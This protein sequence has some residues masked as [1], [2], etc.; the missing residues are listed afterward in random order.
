MISSSEQA[1]SQARN[2]SDANEQRLF[3]LLDAMPVA[4]FIGL[5]GGRPYYA[6]AEAIRI[7]GRGVHP[8]AVTSELATVYQ[9][10]IAGTDDLYP[11][12]RI[13]MVRALAGETVHCDD[14]EIRRPDGTVVP[15]ELW[16]TPVFGPAGSID[17][18]IVT[19]VETTERREAEEANASQA[20][21]IE[22]AHDAIFVR[23]MSSLI[24]FWN[25]GAERT[26]G[27]A[28]AEALGKV[29]HELL[30]TEFPEPLAD[31]KAR[32]AQDGQ[33]EGE[34]VHTR[35]DG[36]VIVV[37]SRWVAYR[38]TD[39]R[40]AGAIE[41]NRDVTIPRQRT[42]AELLRRASALEQAN[43]QLARSNEELEQFAY[44]A[45]H[46]L[47]EP[48]RAISGPISL[49]ARRY[50]G[51]LDAEADQFIEFAVDGCRRMQAII[52]DLLAL[53]RAGRVDGELQ[54]VD[55]NLLVKSV[56]AG[57]GAR[58][59]ETGAIV[60][61][62]PLPTVLSQPTQLGQVFQNLIANALKFIPPGVVPEVVV[63]A[64]RVG[65]EWDFSVTDNGIGIEP[66]HRERIFGMF[67]RLHGRSEYEGSGIGLAL[68]KRIVERQGGR[69]GVDAA[70][71]GQGSCFWFALPITSPIA[72]P[73]ASSF[74]SAEA[75]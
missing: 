16:A 18:S 13:P 33:W 72:S 14:M 30:H 32:V 62:D 22:L 60:R 38:G 15:L 54:Q 34:L 5:P 35:S 10:Y 28:R 68:C 45:S 1:S 17:Q 52:D 4:V 29:C 31:I 43:I 44:I 61:V 71:S 70:P 51:Q 21:L 67:K 69:I 73:V 66:R 46:D 64:E 55:C 63:S 50:N 24:T 36:R 65:D 58:I 6:N 7:L 25:R 41:V 11:A 57:L 9:A 23:D 2:G 59:A 75:S 40:L 42:E 56:V 49:L 12:E 27:F 3:Q 53:S 47:S 19:F 48:L 8:S 37:M 74:T 39:G 26:Y 20:A